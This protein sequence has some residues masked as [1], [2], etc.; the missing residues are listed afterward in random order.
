MLWADI[1]AFEFTVLFAVELD[2]AT[3]DGCAVVA[4]EKEC[5]ALHEQLFDAVAMAALSRIQRSQ[6]SLKFFNEGNGV[7]GIR[8]FLGDGDWHRFHSA[9]PDAS[10]GYIR[11]FCQEN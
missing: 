4:D 1:H 9:R 3:T 2:T 5:D 11:G 7:R 10:R 6:M 8:T